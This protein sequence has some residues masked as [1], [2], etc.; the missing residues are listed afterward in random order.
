[1]IAAMKNFLIASIFYEYI[2]IIF[3]NPQ[4]NY[5]YI[6]SVKDDCTR[7]ECYVHIMWKEFVCSIMFNS[8]NGLVYFRQNCAGRGL[9]IACNTLRMLVYLLYCCTCTDNTVPI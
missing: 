3:D 7:Y 8:E 5:R 2:Y 9:C 1:M 6:Y 4:A